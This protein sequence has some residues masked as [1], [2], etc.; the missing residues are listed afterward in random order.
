[1]PIT[2]APGHDET[3]AEVVVVAPAD[4]AA[5]GVASA[6]VVIGDGARPEVVLF[7]CVMHP[8]LFLR[9]AEMA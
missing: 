7:T 3:V 4:A 5:A 9:R 6:A 2:R 8:R 1:L